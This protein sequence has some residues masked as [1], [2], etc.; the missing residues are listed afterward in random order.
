MKYIGFVLGMVAGGLLAVIIVYSVKQIKVFLSV[1]SG[2]MLHFLRWVEN[3]VVKVQNDKF[4]AFIK[5]LNTAPSMMEVRRIIA[6]MDRE[7][8]K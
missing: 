6:Q 8:L 7:L 4:E 1:P 2:R 3:E 5:Q